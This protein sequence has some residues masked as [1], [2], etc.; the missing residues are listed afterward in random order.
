MILTGF[1]TLFAALLRT[2]FLHLPFWLARCRS[3]MTTFLSGFRW[4]N[5]TEHSGLFLDCLHSELFLKWKKKFA[6]L[7][8]LKG[9][10]HECILHSSP[11][12]SKI[13]FL[14]GENEFLRKYNEILY[15][16]VALQEINSVY[17][18]FLLMVLLAGT[19]FPN[20][21]RQSD[22]FLWAL[23]CYH[24]FALCSY[25]RSLLCW[26]INLFWRTV[27]KVRPVGGSRW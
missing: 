7:G 24:Y 5:R 11:R 10:L 23:C 20:H 4:R 6:G 25:A 1:H 26:K 9:G 3:V 14:A 18:R 12:G 19:V 27:Q 15:T 13:C 16:R 22:R 21:R 17:M 2:D 8:V